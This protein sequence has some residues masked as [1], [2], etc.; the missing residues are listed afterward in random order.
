MFKQAIIL[1]FLTAG[2]LANISAQT[3]A[4]K[5]VSFDTDWRFFKA[6]NE[7]AEKSTFDDSKWRKLDVPHDWSIEGPYDR[8]NPTSRGGGYLPAGI[9]WYRKTF[10]LD[11]SYNNKK[12]SIQFDGVMANSDVWIN[13]FHLGKRPYGYISFVYDLTGHLNIG[14]GKTNVLAVRADNSVQPA[15]RYYTGA[16]IYRHVKMIAT[17]PVH[18]DQWSVFITTPQATSQ[19]AI[20][21]K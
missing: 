21:K 12:V 4:R 1:C 7:G 9:G 6:D 2:L 10:S 15:S 18:F 16:G 8:N 11:N 19:K 17:N 14:K 13:G 5:I 3:Q 20:V